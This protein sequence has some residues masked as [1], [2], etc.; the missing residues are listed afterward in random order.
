M[1]KIQL[2]LNKEELDFVIEAIATWS[3]VCKDNSTMASEC[4]ELQKD[5][6]ENLRKAHVGKYI[7]ERINRG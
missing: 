4:E 7:L 3:D 6:S 1:L 2:N 5:A